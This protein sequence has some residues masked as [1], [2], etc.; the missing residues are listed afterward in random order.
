MIEGIL[1]RFD[2]DFVEPFIKDNRKSVVDN[3][4][5]NKSFVLELSDSHISKIT[6]ELDSLLQKV[7]DEVISDANNNLGDDSVGNVT[8]EDTEAFRPVILFYFIEAVK[9]SFKRIH[10]ASIALQV[11]Q[12]EREE[13]VNTAAY[14]GE[15]DIN[16]ALELELGYL[17]ANLTAI[18]HNARGISSYIWETMGDDRVRPTHAVNQG[19][20]FDWDDPNPE[21][22]HPGY[23][24]G[25]FVGE[26]KINDAGFIRKVFRRTYTGKSTKLILDDGSV[27]QAT[28]NHPI[29][30]N[31]GWVTIDSLNVGDYVFKKM[32]ESINAGEGYSNELVPT[33]E[34]VFDTFDSFGVGVVKSPVNRTDFHNDV[35]DDE[36]WIIDTNSFLNKEVYTSIIEKIRKF[37]FPWADFNLA[38]SFFDFDSTLQSVTDWLPNPTNG[39]MCT[40]DLVSALF[41]VHFTPFE[42]FCFALSPKMYSVGYEHAIDH[43]S[44]NTV[45]LGDSIYAITFAIHGTEFIKR[46]LDDIMGGKPS[47]CIYPRFSKVDSDSFIVNTAQPCNFADRQVPFV[48]QE[49]KI[50]DK[51]TGNGSFHVYNLETENGYYTANTVI[52][53]N[54]RCSAIPIKNIEASNSN[55]KPVSNTEVSMT[56]TCNLN[57]DA[58]GF[59]GKTLSMADVKAQAFSDDPDIVRIDMYGIIGDDWDYNTTMSQIANWSGITNSTKEIHIFISSLGGDMFTGIAMYNFFKMHPAK[60]YTYNMGV[61]ASSATGPF[62]AGDVRVQPSSTSALI[63]DPWSCGC[64]NRHEARGFAELFDQ[65]SLQCVNMYAEKLNVSREQIEVMLKGADGQD[66]TTLLSAKAIEIGFAT[67]D[68]MPQETVN[69]TARNAK[70]FSLNLSKR[71]GEAAM[72]GRTRSIEGQN[73]ELTLPEANA[74]LAILETEMKAKNSKIAE[75]ELEI[76]NTKVGAESA[77]VEL[78]A[79]LKEVERVIAVAASLEKKLEISDES[80]SIQVKRELLSQ[81]G[82]PNAKDSTLFPDTAVENSFEWFVE[83]HAG[84]SDSNFDG[85]VSGSIRDD[86]GN[87]DSTN[88]DPF[89]GMGVK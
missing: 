58:G 38:C 75:L 5:A 71:F 30:V 48:K 35:T 24:L 68:Q 63:H 34:E 29:L 77:R 62:L 1:Y 44:A 82:V 3:A 4:S 16:R 54:C 18:E 53:H 61:V 72:S 73:K 33:I 41:D 27:I 79:D 57:S 9:H 21:T 43:A 55:L 69:A 40:L 74:R 12:D 42:R 67:T 25:C 46:K 88:N 32:G 84:F 39:I 26:T 56:K 47:S 70:A 31:D 64:F 17:Y 8:I 81:L 65:Y 22:G 66:G 23:E 89:A 13:A 59:N 14:N 37:N 15:K 52:V 28:P 7:V 78:R 20:E 83:N 60:V 2:K 86:E 87:D 50:I 10:S 11:K 49:L 19:I 51:I 80:T 36:V 76:K 6:S 45:Q 85:V